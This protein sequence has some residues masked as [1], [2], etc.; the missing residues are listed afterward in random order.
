MGGPLRIFAHQIA[1]S[2]GLFMAPTLTATAFLVATVVL[3][4]GRLNKHPADEGLPRDSWINWIPWIALGLTLATTFISWASH[5]KGFEQQAHARFAA[6][7]GRTYDDV[8]ERLQKYGQLLASAQSVAGQDLVGESAWNAFAGPLDIDRQYP[9]LYGIGYMADV[10]AERLGSF[11][12]RARRAHH[13]TFELTPPGDRPDYFIVRFADPPSRNAGLLGFDAGSDPSV[14]L[15][16]NQSCDSGEAALTNRITLPDDPSH[17]AYLYME[18]VYLADQPLDT[19]SDR[20]AALK[21]WVFTRF[22]QEDLLKDIAAD[23]QSHVRLQVFDGADVTRDGL[24]YDS[25][26]FFGGW[27]RPVDEPV[28]VKT[29]SFGGH[30][31]TLRFSSKAGYDGGDGNP[32]AAIFA[33]GLL[34]SVWCFAMVWA[35]VMMRRRAGVLARD[36]TSQLQDREAALAS[37][38][39]AAVIVDAMA[40]DYPIT[41]ASPRFEKLTGYALDEVLG[42]NCR[43]LQADDRDQ[44]GVKELSKALR[45]QREARVLLRNYRKDGTPFWNDLT[46][47]PLRNAGGR[48]VQYAGV[49]HDVTD[50][51]MTE[52]RLS[53]QVAVIRALAESPTLPEAATRILQG[54]CESQEWD[55][56][57]LWAM[58]HHANALR[59]IEVWRQP[60]VDADDFERFSRETLYLR[61][62]G[63]PGQVWSRGEAVWVGDLSMEAGF[64]ETALAA[65]AGMTGGCG[66][67]LANRNGLQGVLTFYARKL[68]PLNKNVL[69]LMV[70]TGAQISQFM[71]RQEA[72]LR[73]KEVNRLERGL[74]EFMGDGMVA[75]DHEGYCIYVNSAAGR[76]LGYNPNLLLGQPLHAILHPDDAS[77]GKCE[78][79][80]CPIVRSL[81]SAKSQRLN[82]GATFWKNDRSELAVAYT[83]SPI[84][85]RGMIRGVVITFND[86]SDH[87]RKIDRFEILLKQKEEEMRR[88][89]Q[90]LREGAPVSP[91]TDGAP[92]PAEAERPDRGTANPVPPP[93][94]EPERSPAESAPPQTERFTV[95][96]VEEDRGL[97]SKWVAGL[98]R[99]NYDVLPAANAGEALLLCERHADPI[100]VLV[101][102]LML[103][104]MSGK[105][106]ANRLRPL[107]PE[108]KILYT[109]AYS[110]KAL[111]DLNLLEAGM[112]FLRKP[113]NADVLAQKLEQ[114]LRRA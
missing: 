54:L 55:I 66:F 97:R 67:P 91:P 71:E 84:L 49:L 50:R 10:T 22:R 53:S 7:T 103:S 68:W 85:D 95:L 76:T 83:T 106:L 4:S 48:V 37:G 90:G 65:K 61:E 21:G 31:W 78:G 58:D 99:K 110:L 15:A 24:L 104:H 52:R 43:F 47:T 29:F 73:D 16:A 80:Q 44:K 9:G 81:Q 62:M 111:A 60:S 25:S 18:P 51:E 26:G 8:V 45:E 34:V 39:N 33:G 13:G 20:Q 86:V 35:V 114:V 40:P 46:I 6:D 77:R 38:P 93:V 59:C 102:D 88:L 19:P 17:R 42:R 75:M 11:L 105:A 63:L 3:L 5:R 107:Q 36:M 100:H 109:S 57:A 112:H 30:V 92:S 108:L 28:A 113:F 56:G 70:S 2:F 72:E 69:L 87:Q 74:A 27:E 101:T 94:V 64:P 96:L 32:S 1:G 79:E 41:Y 89:S 98:S 82:D 23:N 12:Y 14:R